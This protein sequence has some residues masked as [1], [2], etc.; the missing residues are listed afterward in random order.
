MGIIKS[1]NFFFLLSLIAAPMGWAHESA[2]HSLTEWEAHISGHLEELRTLE[3]QQPMNK[4][5]IREECHEIQIHAEQYQ[6]FAQRLIDQ[7]DKDNVKTAQMLNRISKEL[8]QAAERK[9]FLSVI[10]LMIVIQNLLRS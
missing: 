2:F 6:Q 8:Y 10:R 9:E 5:Q 1:L 4:E 7:E 3:Q